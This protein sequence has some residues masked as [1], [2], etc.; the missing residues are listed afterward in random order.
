MDAYHYADGSLI[1]MM[2]LLYSFSYRLCQASNED[3]LSFQVR[4]YLINAFFA[5]MM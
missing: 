4:Y 3:P 1:G 5:P 2:M